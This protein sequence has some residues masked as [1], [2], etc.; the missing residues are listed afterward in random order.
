[1]ILEHHQRFRRRRTIA[2]L[3]LLALLALLITALSS[4]GSGD[5]HHR[6]AS[7]PASHRA[8]GARATPAQPEARTHEA[9]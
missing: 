7:D 4:G 9:E 3:A 5:R 1:M 6:T 2:G 8:A